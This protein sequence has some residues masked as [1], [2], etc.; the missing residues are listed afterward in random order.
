MISQ[1]TTGKKLWIKTLGTV[2]ETLRYSL[3]T[4]LIRGVI[5]ELFWGQSKP[6]GEHNMP[7]GWDR[8][9][10]SENLGKAAAL[11]ALPLITSLLMEWNDKRNQWPWQKIQLVKFTQ[12]AVIQ[13]LEDVMCVFTFPTQKMLSEAKIENVPFVSIK[14]TVGDE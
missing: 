7:P 12:C 6:L 4:I 9:N 2:C 5:R 14:Q 8:V 10:I 1:A 13:W 11:R 3:T